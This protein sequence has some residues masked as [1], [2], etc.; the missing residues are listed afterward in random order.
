MDT[1]DRYR[2]QNVKQVYYFSMEFLTGRL[3]PAYLRNL[4]IGDIVQ[5]GLTELGFDFDEIAAIEKDQGLRQRRPR[6]RLAACF[7]DSMATTAIPGHGC[8]I[9][10]QLR[11][12]R[13]EDRQ[14]LPGGVP[15]PLACRTATSGRCARLT[16]PWRCSSGGTDP[17]VSGERPGHVLSAENYESVLAVPYD[18]PGDRATRTARSTPCGSGV[19]RA[20]FR[21]STTA[22]FS[23]GDFMR[24]LRS[25]AHGGSHLPG[26]LSQRFL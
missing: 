16:R 17:S 8:G 13:A 4:G 22:T 20:S 1:I 5:E 24:A 7:L 11:P 6:S 19:R 21:S 18:T 26:A 2:E 3:L 12:F 10:L 14:R 9:Q 25:E 23:R 15:G